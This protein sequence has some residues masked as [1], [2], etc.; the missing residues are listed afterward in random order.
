LHR[1]KK[2]LRNIDKDYGKGES[3]MEKVHYLLTKA[4]PRLLDMLVDTA[5]IDILVTAPGM[6]C[7]QLEF[8]TNLSVLEG[9]DADFYTEFANDIEATIFCGHQAPQA[10]DVIVE[11]H[12]LGAELHIKLGAP[13]MYQSLLRLRTRSGRSFKIS[14]LA[15]LGDTL[16]QPPENIMVGFYV[17]RASGHHEQHRSASKHL[18]DHAAMHHTTTGTTA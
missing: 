8:V 11:A 5:S 3:N 16:I 12:R 1:L 4:G 10:A 15:S 6:L 14:I 18:R 13:S 17:V 2:G 9:C 7:K